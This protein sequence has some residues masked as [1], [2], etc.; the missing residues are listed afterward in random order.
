[1]KFQNKDFGDPLD[2]PLFK[3]RINPDFKQPL[4][5]EKLEACDRLLQEMGSHIF[6]N[7]RN[8]VGL[9]QLPLSE[10][11][12]LEFVIKE[13]RP[14]GL[15]KL[16]N[17]FFKSRA[18]KAWRGGILLMEKGISTPIPVAYLESKK[19]FPTKHSYYLTV[20][21]RGGEEIRQLFRKLQ[22]GEL[23][24]FL[25][26][27]ARHIYFYH[28]RG[29]LHRDLSDG[30]ILVKKSDEGEYVFSLIDTNRIKITKRM[31]IYR[32]I[33][34]I[35]RLGIPPLHQSFFLKQYT[36]KERLKKNIWYWYWINKKRYTH[37]THLKRKFLAI[38]KKLI[39][40]E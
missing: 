13:F 29:I 24:W 14:R 12:S 26:D 23:E 22:G 40:D 27:L 17:I 37:Y 36:E 8:R 34:N 10:K 1:M 4:L 11:K 39:W 7:H 2:L 32:R 35:I 33:K 9:V 6:T 38:R 15:N 21:E 28:E 30:N 31:G 5:L 20:M 19:S 16:K 18:Q 25:R 3:G